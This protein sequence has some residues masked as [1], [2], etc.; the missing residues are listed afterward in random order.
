[1]AVASDKFAMAY[2]VAGGLYSC[3]LEMA[4]TCRLGKHLGLH[5]H[6][7][8]SQLFSEAMRQSVTD[9]NLVWGGL[10]PTLEF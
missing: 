8:V 10:A 7:G 9:P 6:L 2:A 1:M 5:P 3:G 4:L